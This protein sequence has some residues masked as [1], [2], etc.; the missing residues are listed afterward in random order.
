MSIPGV[1]GHA[2]GAASRESQLQLGLI[3]AAGFI[4]TSI[5]SHPDIHGWETPV[6]NMTAEARYETSLL[7]EP[8]GK[9]LRYSTHVEAKSRKPSGASAGLES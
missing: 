1:S 8:E 9:R 5:Y 7:T 6:N 4:P 3:C 2:L